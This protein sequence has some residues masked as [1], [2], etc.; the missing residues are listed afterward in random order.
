MSTARLT[1]DLATARAYDDD[2]RMHVSATPISKA[3]VCEYWGREIPDWQSLRLNPNRVYRMYRHP[4]ALRAACDSF[5]RQPL[6]MG[7]HDA[8]AD[9]PHKEQVIGAVGS[10]VAF[11]GTYLMADIAIWDAQAIAAIESGQV[12]EL[13][14]AYRYVPNMTAGVAPDGMQYDGVMRDI[15]GSHLA[16]V[17]EGRAGHDVRVADSKSNGGEKMNDEIVAENPV[18]NPPVD[19]VGLP[20]AEPVEPEVIDEDIL[21]DVPDDDIVE[22]DDVI[23]DGLD[24]PT[25]I[26]DTA[27]PDALEAA[28]DELRAE[29]RAA[30]LARAKCRAIV[31]DALNCDTAEEIYRLA[32]DTMGVKHD[33]IFGYAALEQMFDAAHGARDRAASSAAKTAQDGAMRAGKMFPGLSRFTKI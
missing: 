8:D 29:F 28:K 16:L 7:H 31:G 13:S 21:V 22:P 17:D 4:E 11:D 6:L 27:I 24:E 1:F 23:P 33:A 26:L 10:N 12:R 19:S 30:N 3:N 5:A 25:D 2:G 20:V 18:E 9:N 15:V 14:C 32:L